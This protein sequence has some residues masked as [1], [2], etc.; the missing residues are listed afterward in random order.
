MSD[1][2]SF[3]ASNNVNHDKQLHDAKVS[4]K[5][6]ALF[7]KKSLVSLVKKTTQLFVEIQFIL[8]QQKKDKVELL[9]ALKHCTDM[10]NK[11][12]STARMNNAEVLMALSPTSYY[13]L[14]ID[15]SIYIYL[16]FK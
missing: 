1:Q 2:H 16:F 10:L 3:M 4:I 5:S 8:Q 7:M 9:E 13:D 15:R 6:D 12:S 14:C 11:L